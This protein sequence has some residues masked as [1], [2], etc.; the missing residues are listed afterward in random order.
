MLQYDLVIPAAPKDFNKIEFCITSAIKYLNPQPKNIFIIAPV[1]SHHEDFNGIPILVMDE[2]EV[3]PLNPRACTKYYRSEWIYAQF[4]KMFQNATPEEDYLI[5]DADLVFNRQFNVFG[6]NGKRQLFLGIDQCHKPYFDFMEK[7]LG[8]GREY[9]YSFISEIMLFNKSVS[10]H[11]AEICGGV[12]SFYN[13]CA[14]NVCTELLTADYE[15]YGNYVIKN[16]PYLY[17][18]VKIKTNLEGKYGNWNNEEIVELQQK[19]LNK[20]YDVFTY[21]SWI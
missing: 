10:R 11:I 19:M 20:D 6:I 18:I 1:Q 16:Y 15:I 17:D 7:F 9:P 8:F 13:L 21:H 12:A 5:V 14:H 3:L 4:I 2:Q